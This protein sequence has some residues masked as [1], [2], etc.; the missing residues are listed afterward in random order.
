MRNCLALQKSKEHVCCDFFLSRY[1]IVNFVDIEIV[2]DISRLTEEQL[3]EEKVGDSAQKS[4]G[5][6]EIQALLLL[7]VPEN[8]GS[9]LFG[10]HFI[11]SISPI[12][13]DST[14]HYSKGARKNTNN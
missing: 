14:R 8:I 2:K 13:F 4:K 7:E 5:K 6:E 11:A 10:I 3:S 12:A 1:K 9:K